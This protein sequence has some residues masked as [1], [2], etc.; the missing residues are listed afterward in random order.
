DELPSGL[1]VIS[2]ILILILLELL[3]GKMTG[4]KKLGCS[5]AWSMCSRDAFID[6]ELYD[7]PDSAAKV[8]KLAKDPIVFLI[9]AA[10]EMPLT[11]A[12]SLF[13]HLIHAMR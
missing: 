2:F 9:C 4:G 11:H 13:S 8:P 1:Q 10:L 7:Q 3:S 12:S 5:A 6:R